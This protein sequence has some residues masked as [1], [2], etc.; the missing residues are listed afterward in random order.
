VDG[1]ESRRVLN[2]GAV[3]RKLLAP[4]F[5]RTRSETILLLEP[6]PYTEN[7]YAG[8][9]TALG[10]WQLL[11]SNYSDATSFRTLSA[12]VDGV[13]AVWTDAG[14]A[15]PRFAR[16]VANGT[17]LVGVRGALIISP[18]ATADNARLLQRSGARA[19]ARPPVSLTEL[20]SRLQCMLY[21]DR[22]RLAQPIVLDRRRT[23]LFPA[24]M[25]A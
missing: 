8:P 24:P 19:W 3:A 21:G 9:L 6:V 4:L 20:G 25:P 18:F 15:A 14:V 2:A 17:S 16:A 7:R 5:M 12:E 22:R 23:G 10:Y 11:Y 13:V 1:S